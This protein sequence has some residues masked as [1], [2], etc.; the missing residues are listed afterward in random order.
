MKCIVLT[1]SPVP[2]G[3]DS[4][5]SFCFLA[6]GGASYESE[7]WVLSPWPVFDV[8][9]CCDPEFDFK[10]RFAFSK[11]NQGPFL[12]PWETRLEGRVFLGGGVRALPRSSMKKRSSW[13]GARQGTGKRIGLQE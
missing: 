10:K 13:M 3:V 1:C 9:D 4:D 11:M 2:A 8:K 7:V 12:D 6:H 5:V